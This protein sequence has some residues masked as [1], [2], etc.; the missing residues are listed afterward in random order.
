[1]KSNFKKSWFTVLTFVRINTKRFFR[2]RTAIFFTIL[3]PLIFLFVFGS[4]NSGGGEVSFNVAIINNSQSNFAREF[5]NT[6]NESDVLVVNEEVTGLDDAKQKMNRSELDATLILPEA[7][8][9]TVD[10]QGYPSGELKV[11]YTQNN[12]QS[13]I[14]LT[15]ILEGQ[16][17]Q[18]NDTIVPSV[19]PF[20]VKGEQLNEKSLSAFDYT[21]AGLLGFAIIGMGIFGP[22]NVFPELKKM[23]ILR[24]LS[25]TPLKV[26][27]YFVSTMIGQAIIGLVAIAVM[28]AVAISVF[29]LEVVG[30]WAE[31]TIFVIFSIIM[32][33]GIG[34]ALGGWAKNERQV[35]PLANIIVF[36]MM[37]LSGTFFPRF[38][39]PEWLQNI[40]AFL[41]LT[42]VIDGIRL[43]TTEGLHFID[44]LP[45]IGLI[46]VWTVV[47][48]IVAF[49]VFRWE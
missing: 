17:R 26:W 1:M 39:M 40:S 16:F 32:I 44:I 43:I 48:Y 11:L 8:G 36:P 34:L 3:F 29:H 25:T 9:E 35:A 41:P 24:R 14:A 47:I 15:S 4:L 27:Q 30:N 19:T 21:F 49:K 20:T 2:D 18:I 37:F 5:V 10:G 6:A 45:Q 7:F 31:L 12:Q 38:L 22:I 46:A 33:L 13:A 28:F 23:G 42:P